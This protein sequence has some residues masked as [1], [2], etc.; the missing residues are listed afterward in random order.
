MLRWLR[1]ELYARRRLKEVLT[2]M[3]REQ[4][5]GLT[6][7]TGYDALW[8]RGMEHLAVGDSVTKPLEQ[9][10]CVY[11]A[12][13]KITS[14][15]AS[16][17]W[18]LY[19]GKDRIE[20][21]PLIDILAKPNDAM[22]GTALLE[23]TEMWLQ[24]RGQAFWLVDGVA[25]SR[26]G[27]PSTMRIRMLDADLVKA[28][29]KDD[30]LRGWKY[31][32][33]TL[34]V[35]EVVRFAYANP[36]NP[37]DGLS[38]LKAARM[39]YNLAYKSSRWQ[40]KFYVNGGFPP[41]YLYLPPEGTTLSAEERE[42]LKEQFKEEYL[43]IRNAWKPPILMRGAEL[44]TVAISQRDAEWMA[45]QKLANWEVFAI[46]HVP[47]SIAGYTEDA[48]RS[49]SVE[50]K[51]EFWAGKIRGD[52]TLI[53]SVIN[54]SFIPAHWSNIR[55]AYEWQA[56]F[57]EVMPEEIRSSITSAKQLMDMGVPPS[58]CFRVLN[59]AVD[60]DG[61]PWLDEG[62]LPFNL[63]PVSSLAQEEPA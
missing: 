54:S 15:L 27:G 37:F 46:Y 59:L 14:S 11:I 44:R 3:H 63:M 32:T 42:R 36:S 43:G 8:K 29:V 23:S 19:S 17:P 10:A 1:S 18:S 4:P 51:R 39:G 60:T 12:V 5:E 7:S 24:M 2:P 57:S 30:E 58:E 6:R 56:K 21:H 33:K 34:S 38:P 20:R 28:D 48:N 45:T 53:S 49:I 55:F 25:G 9:V 22:S 13:T 40:E 47:P 61:K 62:Y 16:V 35:E 50:D 52:G 26:D 31:K 41:F